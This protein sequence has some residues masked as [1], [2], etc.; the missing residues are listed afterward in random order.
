MRRD[1]R[2]RGTCGSAAKRSV[3]LRIRLGRL[4]A[5]LA[6]L[7]QHG[8][9]CSKIPARAVRE[10]PSAFYGVFAIEVK[11][12]LVLP[13]RHECSS[14]VKAEGCRTIHG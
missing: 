5:I 10:C 9:G 2:A 14:Q 12:E 11:V 13:Y 4:T 6:E 3:S 7:V 8:S 1:A